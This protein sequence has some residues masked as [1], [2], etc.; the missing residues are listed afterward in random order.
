MTKQQVFLFLAGIVVVFGGYILLLQ[1]K[2]VVPRAPSST[3]TL[4]PAPMQATPST[5]QMDSPSY[6]LEG[7]TESGM[8]D[9]DDTAAIQKDL[10][11]T[12][13]DENFSVLVE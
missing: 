1:K 4:S 13:I 11:S 3:Q 10:D 6:K 7:T 9:K 8:S 12:V 2:N 5:T